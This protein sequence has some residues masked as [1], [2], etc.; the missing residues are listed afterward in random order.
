MGKVF[1]N[2]DFFSIEHTQNFLDKKAFKYITRWS[3]ISTDKQHFAKFQDLN[4]EGNE[5]FA[6][7]EAS[8]SLNKNISKA[9]FNSFMEN[10]I[11]DTKKI[12]VSY[13]IGK[14]LHI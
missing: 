7:D 4:I 8:N 11:A 9:V 2:F 6:Y 10:P 13:S 1:T 14:N 5:I 3:F 12:F